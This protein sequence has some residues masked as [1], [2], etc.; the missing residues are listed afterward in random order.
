[1]STQTVTAEWLLATWREGREGVRTGESEL[2]AELAAGR[3]IEEL[4]GVTPAVRLVHTAGYAPSFV[5]VSWLEDH[6]FEQVKHLLSAA[7]MV[8]RGDELPTREE[9][10]KY[11]HAWKPPA[12]KLVYAELDET[13]DWR[14]IA[15]WIVFAEHTGAA[16]GW[17]VGA[18]YDPSDIQAQGRRVAHREALFI[19]EMMWWRQNWA[20]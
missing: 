3:L 9:L 20:Q 6:L 8:E 10:Q 12:G 5:E 19:L 14:L 7:W 4:G 17:L 11:Y 15:G 13:T 2:T 1:M 16:V 18:L